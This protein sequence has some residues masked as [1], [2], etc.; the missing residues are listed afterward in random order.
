MRSS[1]TKWPLCDKNE[2]NKAQVPVGNK[3]LKGTR[4]KVRVC[5]GRKEKRRPVR[6]LLK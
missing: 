3:I 1:V 2:Y 4:E 6:R 5:F